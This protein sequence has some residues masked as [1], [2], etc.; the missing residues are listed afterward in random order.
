[1]IALVTGGGGF[2]GGAIVRM[3]LARGCEVRSISRGHYPELT[4]LGVRQ[5]RGDIAD[6]DLLFPAVR[7]CDVVYHVAAKAGSWGLASDYFRANVVGTRNVIAACLRAGVPKLVFTS[8]P[9]VVHAG[10]DLAGVNESI[11]IA[12]HF[13]AAYP[14][15][16][17]RAELEVLRANSPALA[18]VALRPHLVWGPGDNHL[19]PRL[20][21][22]VAAGKFR[23]IDDGQQLVDVTYVD[24][25]AAAHLQ[26]EAA[27]SP[28][29]P[30][31]GRAYFVSQGEPVRIKPFVN[32]IVEAAG[33][34]PVHKHIPYRLAYALGWILEWAHRAFV[35]SV[36]P[37]LTRFLVRQF[38]TSHY[39]DISAARRDFGYAPT[40]GID[41]GLRRLAE[42][43]RSR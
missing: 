14:A 35:P 23:F 38:A 13:E 16:K 22:R 19:V 26:A 20:V 29:S 43:L 6:A 37:R 4:R 3:L 1:M 24:N 15:T 18:T 5:L 41:E 10:G 32:R 28:G 42:W 39:Y 9:S 27:L 31:A 33:L 21:S 25:A 11:P 12:R 36:E 8:S 2:L 7:G 34:P 17:A 30:V 40:V